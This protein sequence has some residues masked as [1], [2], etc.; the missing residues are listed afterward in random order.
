MDKIQETLRQAY[1]YMRKDYNEIKEVLKTQQDTINQLVNANNNLQ[2]MVKE[3][4]EINQNLIQFIKN[5][6]NGEKCISNLS[7]IS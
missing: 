4:M 7:E 2:S 3:Q 1:W 5:T 6:P